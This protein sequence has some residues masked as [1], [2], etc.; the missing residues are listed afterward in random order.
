[1]KVIKFGGSSLADDVQIRKVGDIIV[2]DPERRVVV[3]SAPGKGK[4]DPEKVTDMLIRTAETAL[5]QGREA[6]RAEL[7]KIIRCV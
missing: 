3:V 7:Q 1:M 6:G 4:N 2:S 5:A